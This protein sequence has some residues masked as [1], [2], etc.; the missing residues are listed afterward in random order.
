MFEKS[1]NP[2]FYVQWHITDRCS[3]KCKHCYLF[4][5][6]AYNYETKKELDIKML[7]L[8]AKDVFKTSKVL[9]ANAVFVL[10]GGDPILHPQF[11][12][13]LNIIN[14]YGEE[15]QIEYTIDI[16]GNPFFI[17]H[18]SA[19]KMKKYGVRKY[20]LS[21]DGLKERHDSLR[22]D[23]SYEKTF[24]AAEILKS[25]G[26][27][28]S[29]MFTLSKLNEPDLIGVM[30]EIAKKRFNAFA[31]ARF[32]RPSNW[33]LEDYREQMF[34][35]L[36][37]KELLAKV[38]RTHQELAI[39][40][41]ETRFVLKDHLWELFF[42]EKYNREDK[43]ELDKINKEGIIVGGCSIG[44]SG[45]SILSDGLAYACRRF[46]SPIGRVPDRSLIDLF[47]NSK[48]LNN[49]RDIRKYKK[50]INCPLL[51]ICRGCGA[52]AYGISDSCFNPD[53]QCWYNEST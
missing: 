32:C 41:P 49:Y 10:T 20:Q 3:Q 2:N 35:P 16:L 17:N 24:K 45:V 50:C 1:L 38:D 25:V 37:Y 22:S 23:G 8:I 53:P 4:Q 5:S 11:W 51:Y 27:K 52:I 12:E 36:E 46:H 47:I 13:L 40:Y 28:V 18:S 34:S 7:S 26:I 15:F 42:Y 29:C 48:N 39:I 21:L 44:V 6:N 33:S 30:K 31:F 14:V 43:I 19:L 9:N